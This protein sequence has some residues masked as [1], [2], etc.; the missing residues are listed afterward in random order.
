VEQ[1]SFERVPCPE[2]M[3]VGILSGGKKLPN[4]NS[5]ILVDFRISWVVSGGVGGHLDGL[6]SIVVSSYVKG[7]E[8]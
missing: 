5:A 6:N 3:L 4:L 1:A 8:L 2:V 7:R